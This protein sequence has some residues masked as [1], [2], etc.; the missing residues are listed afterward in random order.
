M[1]VK[2]W[3]VGAPSDR[4]KS[5]RTA[6][7]TPAGVDWRIGFACSSSP[8]LPDGNAAAVTQAALGPGAGHCLKSRSEHVGSLCFNVRQR[9]GTFQTSTGRSVAVVCTQ[10]CRPSLW[11]GVRRLTLPCEFLRR[12]REQSGEHAIHFRRI[13][14]LR[15]VLIKSR[16]LRLLLIVFLSPAGQC[17]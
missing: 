13:D 3:G 1:P 6:A 10:Y 2:R 8:S 15:E 11:L 4:F 9:T 16:G 7:V 17:D 14:R 12:G 5:L